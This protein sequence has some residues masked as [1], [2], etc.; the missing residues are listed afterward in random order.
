MED[1]PLTTSHEPNGDITDSDIDGAPAPD[2]PQVHQQV[3]EVPTMAPGMPQHREVPTAERQPGT[4]YPIT[5]SIPTAMS[6]PG[7]LPKAGPERF[8]TYTEGT[9]ATPVGNAGENQA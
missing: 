3:P 8:N 7:F 6:P 2:A 4:P 5:S 9:D 1:V